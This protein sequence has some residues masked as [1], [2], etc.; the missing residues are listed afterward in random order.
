M[1]IHMTIIYNSEVMIEVQLR[2]MQMHEV[3]E[4]G[5][6]SHWKYKCKNELEVKVNDKIISNII[7]TKKE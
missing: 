2:G 5:S 3:A 6:A 7:K 1:A 4:K